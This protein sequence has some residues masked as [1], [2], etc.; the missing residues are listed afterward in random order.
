MQ[1]SRQH[2][3]NSMMVS[4]LTTFNNNNNSNLNYD[5]NNNN[6]Q[7][8]SD[9]R[10]MVLKLVK[11]TTVYHQ[12]PKGVS[13]D[14]NETVFGQILRGESPARILDETEHAISF[15][16]I[17]PKAPLHG[18]VI[19]KKLIGSVFDLTSDDLPLLYEMKAIAESV[20]RHYDLDAFRK[21]NYRLCFHI[22]PY[23]SVDHLHLHILAPLSEMKT[24]HRKLIYDTSSRRA[25]DLTD[26]L[27][28][29]KD[30]EPAVPYQRPPSL[31]S[32][33]L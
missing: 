23:N 29:L 30:G 9:R 24:F 22:P 32:V 20:L 3:W 18:L 1:V 8:N 26:V 16:D 11:K 28:R 17:H 15:L 7:Q 5:D 31:R 2:V 21:G 12:P 19:P 14:D 10:M 27:R 6:N 13:Y 4:L 33:H 25:V